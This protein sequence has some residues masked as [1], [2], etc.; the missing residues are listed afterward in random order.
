MPP[1]AKTITPAETV[2]VS[3]RI[4][5]WKDDEAGADVRDQLLRRL[6]VQWKSCTG[7]ARHG[8]LDLTNLELTK[9]QLEVLRGPSL[10]T[11]LELVDSNGTVLNS[12][13]AIK[14]G[15][16]TSVRVTLMNRGTEQTKSLFLRLCLPPEERKV[17]LIGVPT[18]ILGVLPQKRSA[19][20]EFALCLLSSGRTE[21]GVVA[22]AMGEQ[23]QVE[24]TMRIRV[25]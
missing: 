20:T 13:S 11:T 14:A 23:W 9:I 17:G 2:H 15:S 22:R 8:R 16:F 25:A 21:V 1:E 19:T 5:R 10:D 3:M 24:K 4:T 6:S 12:E 18:R 7:E